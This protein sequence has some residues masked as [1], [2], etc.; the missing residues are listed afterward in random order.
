[1][2]V[3][4]N[5]DGRQITVCTGE[6][7]RKWGGWYRHDTVSLGDR[8]IGTIQT[9]TNG[10]GGLEHLTMSAF[11]PGCVLGSDLRWLIRQAA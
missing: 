4:Y 10:R 9:R 8:L 11:H 3:T 1:M 7:I 6:R 2:T 5:I